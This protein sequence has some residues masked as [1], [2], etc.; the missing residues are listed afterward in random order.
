MC[1]LCS[2]T[3]VPYHSDKQRSYEEC[4]ECGLVFV[5]RSELI[6]ED[7]EKSRYDSHEI[8]NGY[9]TYLSTIAAAIMPHRDPNDRGL[10]FGCGKTTILA[11]VV[12][13]M[14]SYDAF[15]RPEES[16]L[17][18]KYDF[19]VMS[20]VIEHLRDP[21]GTMEQL[22]KLAPKFFIKTKLLPEKSKFDQWFYK[23]DVT[24]IQFF[25][26]KSF[27]ALGFKEWRKVGEDIYLF[28][29]SSN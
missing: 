4:S 18:K 17:Q 15:Y 9:M 16:L 14:D 3:S 28:M 23:R 5:P 20:E 29:G 7:A 19:V 2:G 27:S 22:K 11:D 13:N 24:H 8:D 1:P 6:S 12:G 26:P 10:D 21:R 25:S